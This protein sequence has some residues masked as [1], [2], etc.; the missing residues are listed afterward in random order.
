MG[1]RKPMRYFL[2]TFTW[3]DGYQDTFH[4]CG[5]ANRYPKRAALSSCLDDLTR[6]YSLKELPNPIKWEIKEVT[7]KEYQDSLNFIREN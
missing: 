4:D 3:N 5:W 1:E 6:T 2:V 7:E